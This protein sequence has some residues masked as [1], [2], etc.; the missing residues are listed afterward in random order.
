[1][2]KEEIDKNK[3]IAEQSTKL[4]ESLA[5]HFDEVLKIDKSL[6][7]TLKRIFT[8]LEQF[9]HLDILSEPLF[10]EKEWEEEDRD[11]GTIG[12]RNAWHLI[13]Y[14][15]KVR[16]VIVKDNEVIDRPEYTIDNVPHYILKRLTY[17]VLYA[18]LTTVLQQVKEI[19]K[20][21][22]NTSKEVM[23]FWLYLFN[24]DVTQK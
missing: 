2:E 17:G 4:L 24:K 7:D 13:L 9:P 12:H 16:F 19:E 8:V 21:L 22:E 11:V 14:D 1:M 10:V 23:P 3:K 5:F 15:G 6:R 18:F 20:E